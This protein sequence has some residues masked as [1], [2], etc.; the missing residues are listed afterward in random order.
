VAATR[1]VHALVRPWRLSDQPAHL[2][3]AQSGRGRRGWSCGRLAAVD[4]PEDIFIG[5]HTLEIGATSEALIATAACS[6]TVRSGPVCAPRCDWRN[7]SRDE[8]KESENAA[9]GYA[10][11]TPPASKCRGNADAGRVPAAS[12]VA[13]TI[14][15]RFR[16]V[17]KHGRVRSSGDQVDAQT[18]R[19][20]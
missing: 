19:C 11:R 7:A 8:K 6:A 9:P 10:R 18:E 5:T 16:W 2:T 4:Q 17:L 20:A 15:P 12:Q 1:L 14:P 13:H 3:L